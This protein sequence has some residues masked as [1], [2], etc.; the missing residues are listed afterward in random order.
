[1]PRQPR[2]HL[3]G[4][5]YHVMA[6]GN[7]KQHIFQGKED[8]ITYLRLMRHYSQ[9]YNVEV[10]GYVLLPNHVHMLLK[11]GNVTLAKFMQGIQQTYTQYF[12][13]EQQL[14]GHVFQGRYNSIYVDRDEYLL[15]LIRYIHLNPVKAG[16]VDEPS[17]Y[18]WSSHRSYF[19]NDQ[20]FVKTDFIK[21]LLAHYGGTV[22]DDYKL[23]PESIN[24]QQSPSN[25]NQ[26]NLEAR[27][28]IMLYKGLEDIM[29]Q[30]CKELEIA[31]AII[32]G[33][34]RGSRA[35]L[36]RRLFAYLACRL[37]GHR[38]RDVASYLGCSEVTT[39]KS[40]KWVEENLSA[41]E[42]DGVRLKLS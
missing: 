19:Y 16:L 7:R 37:A 18:I 23:T 31:P 13:K 25:V 12:N 24:R 9:R 10:H 34:G 20:S 27:Q 39:S 11:I 33:A 22:I 5:F 42:I 28:P 38:L 1:M 40:V 32:L 41:E 17:E 26:Y 29:R 36:A 14:V 8:Y 4:A 30:L 15:E 3:P 2:L 21:Q 35:V 6:R